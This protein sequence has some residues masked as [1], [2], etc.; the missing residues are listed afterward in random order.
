[1]IIPYFCQRLSCI[2]FVLF[3]LI[4]TTVLS[5]VIRRPAQHGN[6]Y[7]ENTLYKKLIEDEEVNA[8]PHADGDRMEEEYKPNTAIPAGTTSGCHAGNTD[9][10]QCRLISNEQYYTWSKGKDPKKQCSWCVKG[11]KKK[12]LSCND[13]NAEVDDG[14]YC[15][16]G[17][18][19]CENGV[20]AEEGKPGS[21]GGFYPNLISNG[22]MHHGIKRIPWTAKM[23]CRMMQ[24]HLSTFVAS[25]YPPVDIAWHFTVYCRN[26]LGTVCTDQCERLSTLYDQSSRPSTIQDNYDENGGII[27][28]AQPQPSVSNYKLSHVDCFRCLE[29]DMCTPECMLNGDCAE[30]D[31]FSQDAPMKAYDYLKM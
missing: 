20:V 6:C 13:V 14:W 7:H 5:A 16:P 28:A 31:D 1:M 11:Q 17:K 25:A 26:I 29:L 2:C 19:E 12:C 4:N 27:K 10:A 30:W 23:F 3:I 15:S 8:E 21:K 18:S 9:R 22:Y 24:K